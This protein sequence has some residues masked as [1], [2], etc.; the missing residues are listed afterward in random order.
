MDYTSSVKLMK[1]PAKIRDISAIVLGNSHVGKTCLILRYTDNRFNSSFAS[2]LGVDFRDKKITV[3][4]TPVRF[5]IWDTS[6][7]ERFQTITKGYYEKTMAVILVY[8]CTNRRSYKEIKNWMMQIENHAR[9]D[10]VKVLVA[11][12]CDEDARLITRE[13]GEEMAKEYDVAYFET[14]AKTGMNVDKVFTHVA[15]E[16]CRKKL[17]IV[18]LDSLKRADE[19]SPKRLKRDKLVQKRSSDSCCCLNSF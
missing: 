12:K 3:E 1:R 14:S 9:K 10:V 6:G 4:E 11:A 15:N 2:T 17:D 19:Q 18:M 13:E 16:V 8:D 5:K 7:Q